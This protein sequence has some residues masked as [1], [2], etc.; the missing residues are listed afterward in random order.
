MDMPARKST[1]KSAICC[2][3][4]CC[5]DS[6]RDN[7]MA[8]CCCQKLPIKKGASY[9]CVVCFV[10]SFVSILWYGALLSYDEHAVEAP[11]MLVVFVYW[12]Q[13]FFWT[14]TMFVSIAAF[15]AI[16]NLGI[17][18]CHKRSWSQPLLLSYL[19]R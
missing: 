11:P 10:L 13:F 3:F 9:A 18:V 16:C 15:L 12:L 5:A 8:R 7:P 2:R 6:Y 17:P 4:F 1:T 19:A 14:V